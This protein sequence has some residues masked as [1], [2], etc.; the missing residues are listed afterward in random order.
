MIPKIRTR[1]ASKIFFNLYVNVPINANITANTKIDF[2]F[3]KAGRISS[4]PQKTP[5][6]LPKDES[7]YKL[8]ITDPED[9]SEVNSLLTIIGIT[10][11]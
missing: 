1:Y 6:M 11:P 9:F 2:T 5:K 8:P 3:P 4:P 7:A 10:I